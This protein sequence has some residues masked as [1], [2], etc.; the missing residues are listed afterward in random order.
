MDEKVDSTEN[1]KALSDFVETAMEAVGS[2]DVIKVGKALDRGLELLPKIKELCHWEVAVFHISNLYE[3]LHIEEKV[4]EYLLILL[5]SNNESLHF[6]ALRR[7][8][9]S[10]LRQD[11]R[12]KGICWLNKML[13]YGQC[14]N[15]DR[16]L[17]ESTYSI[18]DFY[19]EDKQ[20]EKSIHYYGLALHYSKEVHHKWLESE[21]HLQLALIAFLQ[22]KIGIAFNE[23]REAEEL[24]IDVKN[25]KVI[26]RCSILRVYLYHE[27]KDDD[28]MSSVL[29]ETK[30]YILHIK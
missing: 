28:K 30:D 25:E 12:V 29:S 10:Y 9:F 15:D 14:C 8:T 27:M 1:R 2:R 5:G 16:M 17:A 7:I 6:D 21:I 24:A 19:Y 13:S 11:N 4:R 23:L 3:I 20:F 18:G 26:L 22:K